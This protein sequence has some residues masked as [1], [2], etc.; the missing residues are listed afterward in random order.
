MPALHAAETRCPPSPAVRAPLARVK[1]QAQRLLREEGLLEPVWAFRIHPVGAIRGDVLDLGDTAIRAPALAALF[2]QVSAVAAA[3]CTIGAQVEARVASLFAARERVSG[4]HARVLALALDELAGER[5][6]RLSDE[7]HARI[8][9]AARSQGWH[10][11]A[12]ES[13]GD[14][15]VALDAQAAVLALSGIS[16]QSILMNSSG[17]LWPL[18]SLSFVVAL[19]AAVPDR[20]LASRCVRC[21]SRERCSQRR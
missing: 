2:G 5:L 15:G 21:G 14:P 8:A 13:P 10:A 9:R 4:E 11:G 6:F 19:G 3:A 17:M 12:P 20:P 16:T 18:K 7:L 1:R